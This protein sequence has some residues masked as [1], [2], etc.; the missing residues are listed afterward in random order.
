MNY[1]KPE[2]EQSVLGQILK[3]PELIYESILIPEDFCLEQHQLIFE[4]M[5]TLK[6]QSEKIDPVTLA[7]ELGAD[8]DKAGGIKYMLDLT[9]AV[10]TTATFGIHEKIIKDTATVRNGL[11]AVS[12]LQNKGIEDP[13]E[14]VSALMEI[15]EEAGKHVV[16]DHWKHI[17]D[18]VMTHFDML[19]EKKEGDTGGYCTAG[20]DL[21]HLTGKYQRQTLNIIAAR[22]SV[23]K[24][25]F[26]L[27]NAVRSAKEGVTVAIF[28]LEQPES[29]LYDRMIAAECNI[30][31]E[32]IRTGKLF[33]EEWAKYTMGLASLAELDIFIDDRP[34]LTIHEI[35]SAIRKLKKKRPNLIVFIDYLQL[36]HGG[37]STKGKNRNEEVGYISSSLKQMS[38]ENDCPVIAL[39]QLSRSVEQRQDKRPMMS[40]LRES[41][42]IEQDADIIAFLYR[43]DYYNQETEK[44][45][46]I[47]I[48]VAKNRNGKVGTVDMINLKNI[49]KFTDC[50]RNY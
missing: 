31:G 40:D 36:I 47:E 14:L 35:R 42:N 2:A 25:A 21:D 1:Y 4:A 24:T 26:L 28:S 18:G 38:R 44:K 5:V 48:I 20:A 15:A 7:T 30:D 8:L 45:N 33:D 50:M 12:N 37:S 10:P 22:P 39:A 46:I 41:G 17:K 27:N 19:S 29:Q 23:G 49:G 43:D 16:G 32:R 11:N 13:N 9:A 34:G 3:E 6:D